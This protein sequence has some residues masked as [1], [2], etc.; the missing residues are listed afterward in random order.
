M[1]Y[2]KIHSVIRY[3][4]LYKLLNVPG[5]YVFCDSVLI[6]PPLVFEVEHTKKYLFPCNTVTHV[7]SRLRTLFEQLYKF[8]VNPQLCIHENSFS[9]TIGGGRIRHRI[10]KVGSTW[11]VQEFMKFKNC[12][13]K[14]I[15]A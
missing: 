3:L 5:V 15:F 2:A 1:C 11:Y 7:F 10:T 12:I 4:N 6:R 8:F 9:K 13:T 14:C